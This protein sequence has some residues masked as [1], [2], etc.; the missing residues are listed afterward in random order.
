MELLV[1]QILQHNSNFYRVLYFNVK[2]DICILINLSEEQNK[3]EHLDIDS[4]TK[5]NYTEPT[6]PP[7]N[8]NTTIL[9]EVILELKDKTLERWENHGIK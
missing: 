8:F 7:S 1:N 2:L 3:L 9:N 5:N 6:K 4:L